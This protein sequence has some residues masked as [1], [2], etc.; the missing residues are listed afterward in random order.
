MSD[1]RDLNSHPTIDHPVF[2]RQVA[3]SIH[4]H[5]SHHKVGQA[6]QDSATQVMPE[7]LVQLKGETFYVR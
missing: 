7:K 2:R 6:G 4:R 3:P 5:V 1:D